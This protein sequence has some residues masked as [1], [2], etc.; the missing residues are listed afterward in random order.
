M[1]TTTTR[2]APG[3]RD[4]FKPARNDMLGKSAARAIAADRS[5]PIPSLQLERADLI[6]VVER[7]IF[8]RHRPDELVRRRPAPRVDRPRRR[9]HRLIVLHEHV[10]RLVRRTQ[11]MRND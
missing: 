4:T 6:H 9:E 11:K 10:T 2:N 1:M 3:I 8:P 5:K 7:L